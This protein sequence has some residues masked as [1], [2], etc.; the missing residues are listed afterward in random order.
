VRQTGV[1]LGPACCCSGEMRRLVLLLCLLAPLALTATATAQQ[2]PTLRAELLR[3]RTGDTPATRSATFRASMPSARRTRRL[4]M[5]FELRQRLR[6]GAE[7]RRVRVPDWARWER[8]EAR[9]AGF[10][11]TRRVQRLRPG[12]AYRAVV[13]FRWYD[14]DGDVQREARRLTE[15]CVQPAP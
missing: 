9:A 14:A 13:V 4:A 6:A 15:Q 5:R 2:R 12:A 7:F 8:S 1:T 11:F 10:V 3:C